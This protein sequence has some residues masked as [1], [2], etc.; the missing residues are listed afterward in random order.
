MSM[1]SR[2]TSPANSR[3][4][5]AMSE[6]QFDPKPVI[7]RPCRRLLLQQNATQL[8]AL[9]LQVVERP[10]LAFFGLPHL[11][12]RN[13]SSGDGNEYIA[14]VNGRVDAISEA[15]EGAG[16]EENVKILKAN[17]VRRG[18]RPIAPQTA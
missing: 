5:L 3:R 1:S 8:R 15:S 9:R 13:W 12:M 10:L 17:L 18:Y 7:R 11:L 6:L 4:S 14:A 2:S 16:Q